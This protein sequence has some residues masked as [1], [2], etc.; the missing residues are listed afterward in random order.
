MT[1]YFQE[2]SLPFIL[3]SSKIN[4]NTTGKKRHL[5]ALTSQ[6]DPLRQEAENPR[7]GSLAGSGANSPPF[8]PQSGALGTYAEGPL[9]FFF[10]FLTH[11]FLIKFLF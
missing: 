7:I 11:Y 2:V 4:E 9:S 10:F 1:T 6:C 5:G 8:L 3:Y